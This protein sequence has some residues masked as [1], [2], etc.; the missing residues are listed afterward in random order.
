MSPAS[1][2]TI[3]PP[4]AFNSTP[5]PPPGDDPCRRV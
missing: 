4:S 1:S 2:T 3:S 5:R